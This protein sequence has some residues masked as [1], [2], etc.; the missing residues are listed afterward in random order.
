MQNS[1]SKRR[2]GCLTFDGRAKRLL[3]FVRPI[4]FVQELSIQ[5]QVFGCTP[6]AV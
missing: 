2:I 4:D 6:F 3:S 1:L 5:Q